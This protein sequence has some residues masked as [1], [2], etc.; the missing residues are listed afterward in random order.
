LQK[1][2]Q[3]VDLINV[4]SRNGDA[5]RHAETDHKV[6]RKTSLEALKTTSKPSQKDSHVERTK[7]TGHTARRR[8][9]GTVRVVWNTLYP[10]FGLRFRESGY[11]TWIVSYRQRKIRRTVTLGS[12]PAMAIKEARSE[13]RRIL[14][15]VQLEGLPTKAKE[16]VKC[17]PLFC[18]YVEEF[19][20]D[21]SRHWKPSTA[22]AA[23]SG[24]ISGKARPIICICR[25][26]IA[27]C[28]TLRRS[29]H[30]RK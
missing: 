18:D 4:N 17:A 7:L 21:Y 2:K 30:P 10:G 20:A 29:R 5:V 22:M 1:R 6:T 27:A 15:Q 24:T 25:D 19:W 13:A 8:G 28:S 3:V 23:R 9:D 16:Q 11:K 12:V 14:S 26:R